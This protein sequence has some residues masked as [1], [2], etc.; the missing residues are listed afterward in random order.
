[1]KIFKRK[2]FYSC[3]KTW[4]HAIS[5]TK[6]APLA[7]APQGRIDIPFEKGKIENNV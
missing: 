7:N 3:N 4:L 1:M 2:N 6:S 5:N